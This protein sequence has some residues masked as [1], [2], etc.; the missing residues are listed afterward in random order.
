MTSSHRN[1]LGPDSCP[2][3][4]NK[5]EHKM[6]LL[7]WRHAEAVEGLPD[8]T[9]ELTER[10]RRQARKVAEW[11][12]QRRPKK[13]RVLVSPTVRTRQTADA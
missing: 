4:R 9:R 11:L 5:D 8:S 1:T 6:D 10:G 12:E 13:L 2:L 3:K 7:L